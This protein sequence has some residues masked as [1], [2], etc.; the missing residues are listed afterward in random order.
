M[1]GDHQLDRTAP[2]LP[3]DTNEE[4]DQMND[5]DISISFGLDSVL[6]RAEAKAI[7]ESET[8]DGS[9]NSGSAYGSFRSKLSTFKSGFHRNNLTSSTKSRDQFKPVKVKQSKLE[10]FEKSPRMQ[11]KPIPNTNFFDEECES[12]LKVEKRPPSLPPD[13]HEED[14]QMEIK[15]LS[16]SQLNS[17]KS[18]ASTEE[19]QLPSLSQCSNLY[20][21]DNDSFSLSELSESYDGASQSILSNMQNSSQ[22]SGINS[23]PVT[24][25]SSNATPAKESDGQSRTMKKSN[26]IINMF[27]RS[28][29]KEKRSPLYSSTNQTKSQEFKAERI[30]EGNSGGMVDLTSEDLSESTDK[31][32]ALQQVQY[33][34]I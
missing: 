33:A 2:S 25:I 15:S 30:I 18:R 31:A 17:L 13:T 16:L 3:P 4:D 12:K 34:E 23:S 11:R 21:I 7:K 26:S 6:R 24:S 29:N 19:P 10:E 22:M 27:K 32:S 14:D 1:L 9:S 28:Q 20:S 8:E 5:K